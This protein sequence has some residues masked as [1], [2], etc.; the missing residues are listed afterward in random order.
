MPNIQISEKA[1]K[2]L[3][4]LCDDLEYLFYVDERED[5]G[6]WT[7]DDLSEMATYGIKMVNIIMPKLEQ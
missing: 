4:K 7:L 6:Q 5:D 2:E 3:W 1:K